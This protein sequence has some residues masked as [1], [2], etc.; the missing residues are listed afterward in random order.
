MYANIEDLQVICGEMGLILAIL[1][2]ALL[3]GYPKKGKNL[4]YVKNECK[5]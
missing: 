4:K 5:H 2:P 3:L 1:T